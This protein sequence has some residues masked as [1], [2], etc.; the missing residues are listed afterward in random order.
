MA[1]Q[2]RPPFAE[3]SPAEAYALARAGYLFGLPSACRLY[4]EFA[5]SLHDLSWMA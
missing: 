3:L 5:A 4:R 2:P 1:A